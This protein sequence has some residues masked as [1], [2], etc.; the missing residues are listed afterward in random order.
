MF[1]VKKPMTESLKD[2]INNFNI[3]ELKQYFSN[4]GNS[5]L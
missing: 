5:D 3:D 2:F 4:K 1:P